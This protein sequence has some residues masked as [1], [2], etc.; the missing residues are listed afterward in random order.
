MTDI[1][2]QTTFVSLYQAGVG[3][4]DLFDKVMV[5][6]HGRQVYF[7]PPSEA[8]T[9]F[10]DLGFKSLPHQSMPDYLVGCTD[11]HERQYAL[12]KSSLDVHADVGEIIELQP[13]ADA[14][15]PSLGVD[16]RKR[17]TNRS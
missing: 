4:Y 9:Y 12:G 8:R 13:L 7:G 1:L 15:V 16:G 3:I 10:E 2:G 14:L 6:D 11:P 17:F 5:L